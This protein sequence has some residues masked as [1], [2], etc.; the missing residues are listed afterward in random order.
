MQF[1][2]ESNSKS[3]DSQIRSPNVLT[4]TEPG[5]NKHWERT[6]ETRAT[7][8]KEKEARD[9]RERVLTISQLRVGEQ[10]AILL[11]ERAEGTRENWWCKKDLLARD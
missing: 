11:P 3:T 8:L 2:L 4:V 6:S 9:Y 10:A 5:R 1:N 7:L